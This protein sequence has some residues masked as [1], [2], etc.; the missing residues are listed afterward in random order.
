MAGAN[1]GKR[2]NYFVRGVP[3]W[4]TE[5]VL[6]KD[7]EHMVATAAKQ[8]GDLSPALYLELLFRTLADDAGQLPIAN[9]ALLPR[10]EDNKTAAA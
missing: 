2:R 10:V 8:S 3:S 1:A 5:F 4:R 6:S 9:E 7:A